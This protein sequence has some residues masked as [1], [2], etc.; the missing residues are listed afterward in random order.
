MAKDKKEQ[1]SLASTATAST[2][3]DSKSKEEKQAEKEAAAL[4]EFKTLL[5]DNNVQ[6]D[7]SIH[8]ETTLIRFLRARKHD[9]KKAFDMFTKSLKWR[10]EVQAD[11][12]VETAEEEKDA[13]FLL[14]KRN[15]PGGFIKH[16]KQ[17]VPVFYECIGAVN[18]HRLMKLCTPEALIHYHIYTQE[19][20]LRTFKEISEKQ[21]RPVIGGIVVENMDGLSMKHFHTQGMNVLKTVVQIDE[22]NYPETLRKYYVINAPRIFTMLWRI[23]KPWLDENT[24]AKIK[25]HGKD[26]L[27]ALQEDIDIENIPTDLGGNLDCPLPGGTAFSFQAGEDSDMIN[28][29]IPRR[30][31]HE[32]PLVV[33]KSGTIIEYTFETKS[34]DIAFG[35]VYCGQDAK[36]EVV[37]PLKRV[38]SQ[39]HIQSG[40]IECSK[41]GRYV[42]LFDNSFSITKKKQLSYKVSMDEPKAEDELKDAGSN[43]K[44]E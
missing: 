42:L 34:N 43:S 10:D 28:V 31:K 41:P 20:A 21:E 35:A 4:E 11:T 2:S 8:T 19:I 9:P 13:T 32:V 33:E 12:I 22:A 39:S 1:S 26:F 18:P 15:W 25:I 29:A 7:P 16:D 30:T 17:G 37:H 24:L 27:K 44:E 5:K 40:K 14:L 3:S 36:E 38:A 6:Y 23:V